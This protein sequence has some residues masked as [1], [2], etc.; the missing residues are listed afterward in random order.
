M[1]K[2]G[3]G[4]R[5]YKSK[6]RAYSRSLILEADEES[7]P[8]RMKQL[9]ANVCMTLQTLLGKST[10]EMTRAVFGSWL[11]TW[12]FVHTHKHTR[13]RTLAHPHARTHACTHA[14]TYAGPERVQDLGFRL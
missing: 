7:R 14:R 12:C 10:T 9:A 13:T 3:I 8:P 5:V 11:V 4:S 1:R 6:K 2:G